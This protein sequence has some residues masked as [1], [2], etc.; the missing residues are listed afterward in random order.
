MFESDAEWM[1]ELAVPA[2]GCSAAGAQLIG[3]DASTRENLLRVTL[4]HRRRWDM[5]RARIRL[6]LQAQAIIREFTHGDKEAASKLWARIKKGGEGIPLSLLA[7]TEPFLIPIPQFMEYQKGFERILAKS[8]RAMPGYAWVNSVS[9]V[10]DVSYAA[11]LAELSGGEDKLY[12]PTDYRGPAAIWKRMGVGLVNRGTFTVPD[13]KEPTKTR[14][15]TVIEHGRQRRIAG[16]E[17]IVH[18]FVAERRSI[19][20]NIGKSIIMK[21]MLKG[22]PTGPYGQLYVQRRELER[23]KVESKAH[24]HARAQRYVEKRF[25]TDLWKEWR[26]V[27]D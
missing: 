8:V 14:V 27:A 12:T 2:V 15:V 26:R 7:W 21:Q 4:Y 19:L 24:A 23:T 5:I 17:A 20:W 18:G 3:V 22:E 16:D 13:P 10:G 1:H 9:G 6:E 25:L 11:V